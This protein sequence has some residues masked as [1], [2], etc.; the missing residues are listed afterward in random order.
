MCRK[1]NPADTADSMASVA[2][3]RV[4]SRTRCPAYFIKVAKDSSVDHVESGHQRNGHKRYLSLQLT[5]D[6]KEGIVDGDD[7]G[8][9]MVE[10]GAHDEAADAAESV[11]T[12]L[13]GHDCF[14]LLISVEVDC[15]RVPEE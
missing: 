9:G 11:D 14:W 3:A 13:D 4:Y 10:G 6:R 5:I 15:W 2:R 7:G 12:D 8:V 1:I